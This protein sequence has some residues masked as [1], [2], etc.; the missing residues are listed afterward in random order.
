MHWLPLVAMVIA[1]A[2][3][4][5]HIPVARNVAATT[6][7]GRPLGGRTADT[8]ASRSASRGAA[9]QEDHNTTPAYSGTHRLSVGPD[10]D[11][12]DPSAF[13]SDTS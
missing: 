13:H 4:F 3:P 5:P 2:L 12:S 10:K 7:P 8:A 6:A 11:P 9:S 1:S